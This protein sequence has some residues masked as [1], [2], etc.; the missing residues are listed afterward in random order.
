RSDRAEQ[1]CLL[2]QWAELEQRGELVGQELRPSHVASGLDSPMDD[3]GGALAPQ[4][5]KDLRAE[6]QRVAGRRREAV[7]EASG[8]ALGAHAEG[9]AEREVES[10]ARSAR[11]LP[12]VGTRS[13][14][15]VAEEQ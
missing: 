2:G 9:Q 3:R 1:R 14:E 10:R 15:K 4:I 6:R 12:V 13:A 8:G 5:A 7:P 11:L